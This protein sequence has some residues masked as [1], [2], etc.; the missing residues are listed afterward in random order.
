VYRVQH[1]IGAS[2]HRRHIITGPAVLSSWTDQLAATGHDWARR[3][4]SLAMD[5]PGSLHPSRDLDLVDLAS[6]SAFGERSL[7]S[8][9]IAPADG[10]PFHAQATSWNH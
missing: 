10:A 6:C 9:V 3:A 7:F 5:C 1:E 2:D 8:W 4:A